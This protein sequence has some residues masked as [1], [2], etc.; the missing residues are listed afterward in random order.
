MTRKN[1]SLIFA[2]IVLFFVSCLAT[3]APTST[4]I[5][6]DGVLGSTSCAHVPQVVNATDKGAKIRMEN[7]DEDWSHRCWKYGGHTCASPPQARPSGLHR[8]LEGTG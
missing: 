2:L 4:G 6:S 3:S 5:R 7:A 1:F 8:E